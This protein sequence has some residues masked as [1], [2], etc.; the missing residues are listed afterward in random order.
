VI[1]FYTIT[2]DVAEPVNAPDELSDEPGRS[3]VD[4][5]R[6]LRIVRRNQPTYSCCTRGRRISFGTKRQTGSAERLASALS[7]AVNVEWN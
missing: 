3:P 4:N 6:Q 2:V 5:R 7:E 1:V